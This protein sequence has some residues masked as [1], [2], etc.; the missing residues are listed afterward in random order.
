MNREE[1]RASLTAD[2][3]EG[4][5]LNRKIGESGKSWLTSIVNHRNVGFKFVI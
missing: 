4:M 3:A 5:D 2:F 1:L